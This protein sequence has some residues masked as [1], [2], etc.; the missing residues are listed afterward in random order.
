M[1]KW[2]VE[3][4]FSGEEDALDSFIDIVRRLAKESDIKCLV[5]KM[6]YESDD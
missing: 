5:G 1:S 6:E 2:E 4:K 3:I